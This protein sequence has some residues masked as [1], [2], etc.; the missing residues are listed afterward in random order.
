MMETMLEAIEAEGTFAHGGDPEGTADEWHAYLFSAEEVKAWLAVGC[1]DSA[2]AAAL[3]A[4][5][6][7]PEQAGKLCEE[8]VGLGS[9]YDTIA[10]K[11][12]NGDLSTSAAVALANKS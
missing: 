6:V 10:K 7:T 9:Y 4:F 2:S 12:S 5:G 1:F 8:D 3:K 11:L